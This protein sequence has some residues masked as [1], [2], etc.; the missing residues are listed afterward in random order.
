MWVKYRETCI[1]KI[2]WGKSKSIRANAGKSRLFS[3]SEI[4]NEPKNA[5]LC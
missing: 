5:T 3:D 4:G 2:D 1:D